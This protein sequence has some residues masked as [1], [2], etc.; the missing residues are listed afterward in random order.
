MVEELPSEIRSWIN[1]LVEPLNSFMLSVRSGLNKGLTINDN[2][3]GAIKTADVANNVATL[4]YTSTRKPVAIL[5]GKW[6]NTS[7]STWEPT[8]GIAIDWSIGSG[9][10][11]TVQFYGL[12]TADKYTV[13]LVIFDD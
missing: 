2:M 12:N 1:K 9:D 3:S 13:N 11:L 4:K 5:L 6:T 8:T 10:V 7:D